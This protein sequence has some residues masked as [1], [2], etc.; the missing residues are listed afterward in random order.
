MQLFSKSIEHRV[1]SDELGECFYAW[2]HAIVDNNV[3]IRFFQ[4]TRD[5]LFPLPFVN[6]FSKEVNPS[7]AK[8]GTLQH[9]NKQL[10]DIAGCDSTIK[11][12][13]SQFTLTT[14][15]YLIEIRLKAFISIQDKVAIIHIRNKNNDKR[16]LSVN[17]FQK[18]V[19]ALNA[20]KYSKFILI[21][22]LKNVDSYL[23]HYKKEHF[24]ILDYLT[25]IELKTQIED[26]NTSIAPLLKQILL[27][28]LIR[29]QFN[30]TLLIG[31]KSGAGLDMHAYAGMP[32][33]F[34]DDDQFNSRYAA[35]NDWDNPYLANLK[36]IYWPVCPNKANTNPS[37]EQKIEQTYSAFKNANDSSVSNNLA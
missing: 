34:L 18:I 15:P 20:Q 9:I 32:T 13:M 22:D 19:K 31:R 21:G 10:K 36:P 2:L 33:I 29:E 16:N 30:V 26:W 23:K 5:E 4:K 25:N 37:L 11:N 24:H 28:K 27:I 12:Y 14:L 6:K 8:S 1:S 3:G 17:E 35:K 7:G